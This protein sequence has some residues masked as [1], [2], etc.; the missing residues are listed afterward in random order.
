MGK[1]WDNICRMNRKQEEK[2]QNKYGMQ[3]EDNVCLTLKQR[4]NHLQ[5]ELIDALKYCEHLKELSEP[6][7]TIPVV[8]DEDAILP[9]RAHEYDAGADLYSREEATIFPGG[10][11]VFDT[12]VHIAIPAGYVGELES[13]SGLNVK[14]D[15]VGWGTIDSGYTGS[16]C[17]KLYNLGEERYTIKKGAKISQIVIHPVELPKFRAVYSLEDTDRGSNGFGS[18]GV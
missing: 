17:V 9:T 6:D 16:I 10:S 13:K 8:L 14:H 1:Y 11:H 4:I 18:T 12:G 3:L 2:G 5:E 15:L 7:F